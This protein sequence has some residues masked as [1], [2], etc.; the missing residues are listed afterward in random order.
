MLDSIFNNMRPNERM[1]LFI[2]RRGRR[3]VQYGRLV[4]GETYVSERKFTARTPDDIMN[5]GI[6]ELRRDVRRI[7]NEDMRQMR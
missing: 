2:D 3:T 7:D 6:T 1:T 4:N 5:L